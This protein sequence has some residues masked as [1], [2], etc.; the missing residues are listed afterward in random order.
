VGSDSASERVSQLEHERLFLESSSVHHNLCG[1]AG[2]LNVGVDTVSANA[3]DL[4]FD[5]TVARVGV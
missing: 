4:V 3:L 2:I 1:L 5:F